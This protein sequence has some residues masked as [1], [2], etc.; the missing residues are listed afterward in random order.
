MTFTKVWILGLLVHFSLIW[1]HA[2]DF[3]YAGYGNTKLNAKSTAWAFSGAT[4]PTDFTSTEGSVWFQFQS[5]GSI[6]MKGFHVTVSEEATINTGPSTTLP[7][8][9]P[10]AT[11]PG[12]TTI[13]LTPGGSV[14]IATPNYPASYPD[15][16]VCDWVVYVSSGSPTMTVTYNDFDT[17][18]G[19]DY[20]YAGYGNTKL[21]AKSTAWAFSGATAPTDFTSTEG[22]VWFQFQ[23]DGSIGMKGFHVTVS[24][25]ATIN[26]GPST[27]LPLGTP[28]ATCP[29]STTINLTPG[30]SVDIATPNYPANYPDNLVCDWV[31]YVSGGTPTMTVTYNDFDT[32]SGSDYFY[33]GYGNTK[34]NAKSTAWAFS[35]ATAPTDFTSTEGSVWFQFQSDGSIGMK[36]FHV[37]VSEEA[38]CPGS[39][40]INLTPGGSVDIATP[41]YPANYP[42]NLVCDWVVYVSSGS[43]TMT[44]TYND[45]DTESDSDFFYAGH[46]NT[47]LNAK[48]TAWAF[49]GATAPADFKSTEGA[50]WFQFQSDGSIGMKGFHVTVSEEATINTGPSTTL[51]L[52]TPQATCPGSTTI[53]LTPGGS[54]DI[55]TPNYPANYPDNLVCDW[56]VYVS[57]GTP[58]MT[59]TYND[60][61]TESGSDYFYAGYGNTKLNAKSTAWA[62]SGAT[63]PTDFTSTEGAV[64]FQFQSDGSIGMKGFHVTVSEEE[65]SASKLCIS[66]TTIMMALL[67]SSYQY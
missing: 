2:K 33:A 41:N 5:D 37:R 4:A 51:P 36:G 31:V 22:S 66:F 32:E 28:Q 24:D 40:T 1:T 56:V 6:G 34:L 52:G 7:L 13:N 17:E 39:T 25:E 50:V 14:N 62:F 38:T 15:N 49:S 21:N 45:F 27:T 48:S 16:L 29:G 67:V 11:C 3:F 55:A 42:D 53:N 63:A 43:P 30:G 46:G 8:G 54:V 10:Q 60:F 64:W 44:V 23:S 9:T 19:S 58:T 35:G 65:S 59:V 57:G 26:T 18:S 20:F 47:K 12:S 61:D